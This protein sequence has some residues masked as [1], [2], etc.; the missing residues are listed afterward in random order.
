MIFR[1]PERKDR[2]GFTLTEMLVVVAIIVVLASIAV[3]VTLNV[4][5]EQKKEIARSS[6]KSNIVSGVK[7][8]CIKNKRVPVQITELL[9]PP[10]GEGSLTQDAINDPWGQPYKLVYTV[11]SPDN[12]IF[13]VISEG[14]GEAIVVGSQ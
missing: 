1:L 8:F 13:E 10:N 9:A 12:P 2:R 4:L 3:P 14:S 11:E 6:M 5:A 7:Q